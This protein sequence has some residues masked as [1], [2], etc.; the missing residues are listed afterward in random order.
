MVLGLSRR[1]MYLEAVLF[2]LELLAIGEDAFKLDGL[3]E[4]ARR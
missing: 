2:P 1:K 4:R 3:F